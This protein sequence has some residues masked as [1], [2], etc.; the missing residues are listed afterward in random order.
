MQSQYDHLNE[1]DPLRIEL[2]M[3]E[4]AQNIESMNFGT[5]RFLAALVRARKRSRK[6]SRPDE[7]AKGIED[8]LN[9][10]LF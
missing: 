4:L 8:M 10:G 3:D 7:L 1:T 6:S 2:D 5:V 9:K